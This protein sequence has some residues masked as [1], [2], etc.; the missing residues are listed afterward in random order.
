MSEDASVTSDAAASSD[1]SA[2][3][4]TPEPLAAS[5]EPV[6]PPPATLAAPDAV[7]APASP[8]ALDTVIKAVDLWFASEFTG[9]A[10]ASAPGAWN[11]LL[12]AADRLKQVISRHAAAS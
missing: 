12:D 4:A 11:T 10:I 9:S 6:A 1:P 3:A 8:V 5:S 2:L 7:A